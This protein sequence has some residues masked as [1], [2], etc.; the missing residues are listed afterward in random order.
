MKLRPLLIIFYLLM[1]GACN[2]STTP[3]QAI[4][5][6]ITVNNKTK[7]TSVKTSGNENNY[8]F[9]VD[10]LS[11]DTGCAQ[12]ANWWEVITE[13][14]QLIYRRILTHSH[15]NEQPFVRSGGSVKINKDQVVI[16]RLH[17]NNSGFGINAFKGSV[18]SGFQ[19][20]Q[21]DVN[22]ANNLANENPL[23]GP[24]PF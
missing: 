3:E 14:G 21:T 22:F 5:I 6:Q 2:S 17:M 11:P 15:V 19:S 12:Y 16:I 10:V 1:I 7:I 20:Y 24:C 4:E 8:T 13:N 23:P 18:Q 9:S